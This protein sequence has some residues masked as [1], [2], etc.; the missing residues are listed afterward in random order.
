VKLQ[1]LI[2]QKALCAKVSRLKD[3]ID[4][5]V[6]AANFICHLHWKHGQ[7]QAENQNED[8]LYFCKVHYFSRG[9]GGNGNLP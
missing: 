6:K 9:E 1:C 4:K 7:L 2:Q 8:L 5:V 3:V